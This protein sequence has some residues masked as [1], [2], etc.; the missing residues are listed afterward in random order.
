MT[1][2]ESWGGGGRDYVSYALAIETV[3]RSSATLATILIVNNSLVGEVL[4]RF[5]SDAQKAQWQRPAR[6]GAG[7]GRVRAVGGARGHRR[8]QRGDDAPQKSD[9]GS[10]YA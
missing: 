8:G 4:A 6:V 9:G 2:P 5:G 7:H 10:A 1:I 3:A